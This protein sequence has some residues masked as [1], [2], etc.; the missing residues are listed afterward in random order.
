MHTY[1]ATGGRIIK[2]KLDLEKLVLLTTTY[3]Q[4]KS[5]DSKI[6]R[7]YWKFKIKVNEKFKPIQINPFNVDYDDSKGNSCDMQFEK[8][9]LKKLCGSWVVITGL[10]EK[11]IECKAE[12]LI[13][14]EW[15][16]EDPNDKKIEISLCSSNGSILA[17]KLYDNCAKF[18]AG[19]NPG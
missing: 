14:N 16:F 5:K 7:G 13:N 12:E 1:I 17:M 4:N 19:N 11:T 9:N 15:V 8:V 3:G 10:E 18:F 2:I 6:N